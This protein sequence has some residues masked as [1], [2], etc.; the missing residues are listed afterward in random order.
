MKHIKLFE[1]ATAF[2][3]ARATLDLPNVSL[4]EATN[5]LNYLPY[6]AP[7]T[8]HDYVEIGGIK[9]A[10]MNVGANSV[11]DTGLYFQWGDT[12]GYTAAQVGEGEGQKYFGEDDCIY[13]ND[14]SY[15]KYN[16]GDSLITLESTDDAVKAAWGGNWRMP[17]VSEFIA[18][19]EAVNT[20]WTQVN[21]VSG[22]MCT[23]KTDE[24]KTLF[25]PA[26]G[27]AYYGSVYGV[28]GGGYCWSS[29]L[30]ADYGDSSAYL[31]YF[32]FGDVYWGYNYD[33]CYGCPVRG[34]L[35]EN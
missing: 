2:E 7:V 23:D 12:Q 3:T 32:N 1:T 15:T 35:A 4:I 28:G 13:Y 9:W 10:T 11:T 21:G 19:G 26:C 17:T 6:V 20:A 25:F 16:E 14:G 34:V 24:T 22:L 18:L 33:R 31:L 8:Q 27:S 5:E 30:Y 29:S